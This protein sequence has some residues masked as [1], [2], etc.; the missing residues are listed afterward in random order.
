[1]L[2]ASFEPDGDGF[3]FY[4][5]HLSRGIAVSAEEKAMFLSDGLVDGH[6]EFFDRIAGRPPSRP[7]RPFGRTY[8]NMLATLPPGWALGFITLGGGLIVAGM[9]T[10]VPALRYLWLFAG[11]LGAAFGTQQLLVLLKR[12]Q[13]TDLK[14]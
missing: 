14:R 13:G 8:V 12:R 7:R 5:N 4:R 10:K 11:I 3:I 1:M 2:E 6:G 9:A